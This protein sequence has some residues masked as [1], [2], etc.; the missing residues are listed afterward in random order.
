MVSM[1]DSALSRPGLSPGWGC[2]FGQGSL[3]SQCLSL[4]K[5]KWALEFL[6]L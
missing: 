4:S 6:R 3:L 2:I 5:D 1:L